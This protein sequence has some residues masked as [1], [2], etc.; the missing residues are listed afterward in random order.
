VVVQY[1]LYRVCFK[2]HFA[3]I[4]I[5]FNTD[6]I[7]WYHID[8]GYII[9]DKITRKK[10]K[11]INSDRGVPKFFQEIVQH[12]VA[13]DL[14]KILHRYGLKPAFNESLREW[15]Q[16]LYSPVMVLSKTETTTEVKEQAERCLST[17]F[18]V[19]ITEHYGSFTRT[20]FGRKQNFK[21][22]PTLQYRLLF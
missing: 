19:I 8:V 14:V 18:D 15:S 17:L 10:V 4:T 11:L 3:N 5:F 1:I 21:K 16:E 6:A 22:C 13:F 2:C 12:W 7:S 9:G 20:E